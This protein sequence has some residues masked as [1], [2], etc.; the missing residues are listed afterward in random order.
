MEKR[1]ICYLLFP[2]LIEIREHAYETGDKKSFWL[3]NLTHNAPL[4]LAECAD[5]LED[6]LA[7]IVDRVEHDHMEN[8][9]NA[10]KREFLDCYP[11]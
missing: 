4:V 8:W 9:L 6:I 2:A 1:F 5:R 7:Q 11:A 10:R 3:F